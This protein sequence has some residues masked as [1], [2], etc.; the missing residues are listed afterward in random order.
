MEVGLSGVEPLTSR[1]SGVRSNQLS[2]RPGIY[3]LCRRQPSFMIKILYLIRINCYS[4]PGSLFT[5][6]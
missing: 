6:N 2:Y 1:L 5:E 4:R 3:I